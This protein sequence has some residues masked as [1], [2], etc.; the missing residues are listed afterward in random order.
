MKNTRGPATTDV[1]TRERLS[2]RNTIAAH[3]VD[4]THRF[5][6]SSRSHDIRTNIAA[7]AAQQRHRGRRFGG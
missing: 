1:A 7:G 6:V 4:P 5:H 2:I 3:L